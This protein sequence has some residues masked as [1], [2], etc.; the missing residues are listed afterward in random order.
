MN[1]QELFLDVSSG[2]FL[3]GESTIPVVKPTFFSDEQ[4][5]LN[6]SI[7]KIKNNKVSTVT[8]SP[9]SRFK[10]RLGT[11][12][13][14]LADAVD[15]TTAQPNLITALGTITTASS[16]QA[17]ATASIYTY[18][19]VTATFEIF[20][21]NRPSV[22][23]I[24]N[25]KIFTFTE[26]K[27]SITASIGST[28]IP[29]E[30]IPINFSGI[31]CPID[32]VFARCG[33]AFSA[34]L[35]TVAS[36]TFV[37]TITGGVV[38]TISI[39][40][41]GAGYLDGNYSLTFSGGSPSV[42]A[43]ATA[44]AFN[45]E[46]QSVSIVNGG[47]G[48]SS[49][50]AVAL[51]TPDKRINTIIPQGIN[52]SNSIAL[53]GY[54]TTK[55][56]G[57]LRNCVTLGTSIPFLIGQP[58]TSS[59]VTAKIQAVATL[60]ESALNQW[61]IS[62]SCA[63]YG[64][65]EIPSVTQSD[66]LVNLTKLKTTPTAFGQ[67]YKRQ[68]GT[69]SQG[70]LI[71]GTSGFSRLSFFSEIY[72]GQKEY[73]TA[74]T[75]L[76]VGYPTPQ[77]VYRTMGS[78]A[79][80]RKN[81][82]GYRSTDLFYISGLSTGTQTV[83]ING[84]NANKI[85]ADKL[86]WKPIS[87]DSSLIGKKFYYTFTQEGYTPNRYALFSI[88]FPEVN[89]NYT[90]KQVGYVDGINISSSVLDYG[91]G[92]FTPQVE[93]LD[94]GSGYSGSVPL[95]FTYIGGLEQ[96]DTFYTSKSDRIIT[97]P[98][99]LQTIISTTASVVTSFNNGSFDYKIQSGGFGY[100]EKNN[101]IGVSGGTVTNG[102]LTASLTNAPKGYLAGT[103]DCVIAPPAS[104]TTASIQLVV[105]SSE[106]QGSNYSIA[107][108]NPGSGFTSAPVITAPEINVRSGFVT[109]IEIVNQSNNP[110][111]VYDGYG[112]LPDAPI[113][114]NI[115]SSP[116]SG[117]NALVV[118]SRDMAYRTRS[119]VIIYG[120]HTP[121][122]INA[123]FGYT[124]APTLTAVTPLGKIGSLVNA[125]ITNNPVGYQPDKVYTATVGTSPESGGTAVLEFV[126]LSNG[127]KSAYFTNSGYGYTSVPA[128]TA[129]SPDADNGFITSVA[130]VTSGLGYAPG[131]YECNITNTPS[132]TGRAAQINFVVDENR[133]ASLDVIDIGKGY[134]TAPI[135]SVV[136]PSGNVIS[137]IT[138]TCQGSYY[139]NSTAT[140]LIDDLSGGGQILGSPIVNSG[141]ILGINVINGGYNFSN[142]PKLTFSSPTPPAESVIPANQIQG[143][144]NITVA[145]AN[146]ILSTSTQKDILMEVYETDGTNE[147]V[148]SQ[149]TVSLAKRVLE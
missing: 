64:Y 55:F 89:T 117:G 83:E 50:P 51:F 39:I 13:L 70:S 46:I 136:T 93:E 78:P 99:L 122:I 45:G 73:Q 114:F 53:S 14:K 112:Q 11:Q 148:I 56:S 27:A 119:G 35:N 116:V 33:I 63:G 96:L 75:T 17:I 48:Y 103:Y 38:T 22:T 47:T 24:V 66:Y 135:I 111:G 115:Q 52:Y 28:T 29:N 124:S 80:Y 118:L 1:A 85:I 59:T 146:A 58:D 20:R 98:T 95:T 140:F 79:A 86:K 68:E 2:R 108:I 19:P 128:V 15:V 7:L 16:K 91:D 21:D 6:I 34:I 74:G 101:K 129:P 97:L 41:D 105:G 26:A 76:A 88:E 4:R 137:G 123:G 44:V 65:T 54:N 106:N 57:G 143:D 104:G 131:S 139:I 107:I 147:Q 94:C 87:Q 134:V 125:V 133:V 23:P 67:A 92:I 8:P 60:V 9:D 69:F 84:P 5:R 40:N 82:I 43:S 90:I 109:D 142:N 102:I 121:K 100:I 36:A 31:S 42:T 77:S 130:I 49:A 120:Q 127:R 71:F 25:A 144:L 62:V 12:S 10:F 149:A 18:T 141:K 30:T 32:N 61:T 126:I 72:K 113:Y 3:D 110:F 132:T 138:I 145:S 37:A 81:Q